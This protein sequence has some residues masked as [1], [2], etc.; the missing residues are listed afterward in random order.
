MLS[1]QKER[2]WKTQIEKSN[3]ANY[4]ISFLH[5]CGSIKATQT[6]DN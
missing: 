6:F 4:Q 3:V 5:R 2:D 1:Q